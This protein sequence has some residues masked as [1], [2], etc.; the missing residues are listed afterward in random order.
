M[1]A[2][3]QRVSKAKVT[4][5]NEITGKIEK[6][7]VILLGIRNDDDEKDI[8]YMVNKIIN[9]RI[10]DDEEGK[11]NKSLIDVN[12]SILVV[13]N[14]TVYGDAKKGRRPSYI[15]AASPVEAKKLYDIFVKK[16]KENN[17]NCAEGVFQA[18]M[19]VE[20]INDGPITLI[21]ESPLKNI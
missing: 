18:H 15:D 11:L 2:V 6:G 10:F 16:I 9:L 3:I 17:I 12:G 8:D 4:V 1:R 19:D 21:V 20:L 7:I 5:E 14:F 13:S